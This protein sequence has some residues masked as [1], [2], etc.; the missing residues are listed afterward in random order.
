[1]S[2]AISAAAANGAAI[3]ANPLEPAQRE[4]LN[5]INAPGLALTGRPLIGK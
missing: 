4:L 5:L 1:M 2:R 3:L